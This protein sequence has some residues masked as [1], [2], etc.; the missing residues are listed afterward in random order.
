MSEANS[1]YRNKKWIFTNIFFV[2]M[3]FPFFTWSA[4]FVQ[5]E[6]GESIQTFAQSALPK[7]VELVHP[8]VEVTVQKSSHAVVAIYR[9]KNQSTNFSGLVLFPEE[10]SQKYRVTHLAP[11]K[12][13]DG[14]F[15]I[16][17]K[18]V[19]TAKTKLHNN[20]GLVILYSYYRL[21]SGEESGNAAYFYYLDGDSWKID[22]G[23]SERLVGVKNAK[24]ARA[25][26][27]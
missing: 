14:L 25:K 3:L 7:D 12:E 13:A 11:M 2:L 26:L 5:R 18:S 22:E 8:V 19:F 10:K 24:Q 15:D 20:Y 27:K 16:E 4:E 23:L 6:S 9:D 1:N 21:G 17:V